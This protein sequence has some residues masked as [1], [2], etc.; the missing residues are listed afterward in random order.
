MSKTMIDHSTPPSGLLISR[1]LFFTSKVTGTAA[2]LGFRVETAPD[3]AAAQRRLQ[4]APVVCVFCDL[5][6]PALNVAELVSA[7]RSAPRP[8]V[9]AFG[10]HVATERLQSAR[11][12]GCD[13][14]M[15]RSRFSAQLPE[16]LKGYLQG[17][18]ADSQPK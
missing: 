12:A 13:E 16:L 11:D 18:S 15:P 8:K 10:S 9:V 5:A 2:A 4:Q 7:L 14:V 3:V 1:D 17:G 6:D